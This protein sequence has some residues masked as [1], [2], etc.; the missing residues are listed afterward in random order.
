MDLL[1]LTTPDEDYLQDQLLLGLRRTLGNDCVDYPRKDV[2]YKST[3][4]DAEDLYG[5]GFTIWKELEDGEVDRTDPLERLENGEFD[6][7]VFSS[8]HRQRQLFDR[9]E[10]RGI[11][12]TDGVRFVFIDGEDYVP[13]RS[14]PERL[15][16]RGWLTL[17]DPIV[18][19]RS[20]GKIT[21][22]GI[23]PYTKPL[24]P[25]FEPALEYGHYYKRE[26]DSEIYRHYKSARLHPISFGIPE[27]KVRDSE[28]AKTR[29]FPSQVQCDEAYEI[30]EVAENATRDHLFSEEAAYYDN[31]ASA[32]FGITQMKGGWDC[33]RHYEIAANWTVPCFYELDQK[34]GLCAP[35]G[36]QDMQNCL[37]FA[38]A[39]EL[40]EKV[41]YV[42]EAGLYD[43]LQSN[44]LEW[45]KANTA[46]RRAEELLATTGD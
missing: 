17:R 22:V 20:P 19:D 8:I 11:F 4:I 33:M 10:R 36:L 27:S 31:L 35:H 1:F 44:A 28:S 14:V 34:P 32:R 5:R 21:D 16:H 38:S 9:F 42:E 24:Q 45:A 6:A 7:V 25:V 3:E 29:T 43:Y 46:E 30:P 18:R 39:S 40:A 13:H 23:P 26:L 37:M 12:D 41:E 15:L 2:M